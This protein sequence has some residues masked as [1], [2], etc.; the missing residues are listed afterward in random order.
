MNRFNFFSF[1]LDLMHVS[2]EQKKLTKELSLLSRTSFS[3]GSKIHPKNKLC[4]I[5]ASLSYNLYRSESGETLDT[6]LE[7]GE[8][9]TQHWPGFSVG[10]LID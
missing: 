8:A 3:M 9:S 4:Y 5:F 1:G 7:T 10:I 6:V 2:H